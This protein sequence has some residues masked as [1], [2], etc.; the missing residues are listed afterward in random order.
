MKP[1]IKIPALFLVVIT[2]LFYLSCEK[3]LY[4]DAI[5]NEKQ[6]YLIQNVSLKDLDFGTSSKIKQKI[7]DIK[8]LK[9]NGSNTNVAAKFQYNNLLDIYID[10]DNGKLIK[11][12]GKQYYTFPMFRKSEENLENILFIINENGQIDAYFVKYDFTPEELKDLTESELT[13][14]EVKYEDVNRE[15]NFLQLVCIQ[16]WEFVTYPIDEGDLTG[17]FGY[18]SDWVL[19]GEFCTWTGGGGD[20]GGTT[21]PGSTPGSNTGGGGSYSGTT[22]PIENTQLI[23]T[24]IGLNQNQLNFKD[25]INN[26]SEEQQALW[27]NAPD[28]VKNYIK[29][30]SENQQTIIFIQRLLNMMMQNQNITWT[31]IENWFMKE[32]EGQDMFY[33]EIYWENPMLNFQQQ[34][35]PSYNDYINGMPRFQDGTFMTGADN[36]YN[37]VGG[38]VQAAR[39]QYPNQ[40]QNT[41][42]LKV[43][44]AL[45]RSNIVIPNIPGQTLEGGGNEFTGKYFFLNARALN[46]WMRKTFGTNP[47]TTNT[48]FNQNH[49]SFTGNQGGV[50]GVNFP[51]LLSSY[52]GIYSMITTEDYDIN[53]NGASGHADLI[54]TESTGN[55]QCIYGCN[56]MLPIER[57]DIWILD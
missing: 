24:L 50:N 16:V 2:S 8:D 57:I 25:F 18:E 20:L 45:N 5:K 32:S 19:T 11:Q 12:D 30:N 49:I 21:T 15:S 34:N 54:F 31:Q 42:A 1:K 13:S 52:K 41:C 37:L 44:I 51:Y 35:L 48:P 40:T 55:A 7:K 9:R 38:D 3:D 22:H 47:T 10:L 27:N 26:L 33:D 53:Q 23:T 43:S 6:K 36:V 39:V 28:S 14:K 56:F 17:N 4:D 29:D 46:S